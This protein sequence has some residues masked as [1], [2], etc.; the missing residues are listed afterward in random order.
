LK[1]LQSAAR[2]VIVAGGGVRGV[3]RARELVALAEAF[4]NSVVTSL[5][6][7]DS[8]HR[9]S[10]AVMRCGRKPIHAKSANKVVNAADLI[11]FVGLHDRRHD[12][13]FL[14]GAQ[15]RNAGDPD[16]HQPRGARP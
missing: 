8:I 13:A 7:K 4:A 16:R 5:N 12:H 6:G 9:Q 15:D 2:P 3:G 14:G 10:S 1:V 11:C